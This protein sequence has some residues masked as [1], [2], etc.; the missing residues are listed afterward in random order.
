MKTVVVTGASRGFGRA[1]AVE[2]SA[3]AKVFAIGR[4]AAAL[5][6]TVALA[7]ADRVQPVVLDL[8][9]ENAVTDFFASL[10]S[11]DILINNAGIAQVKPLLD[12]STD[13]LRDVLE[14]NLVAAFVVMREGA[15]KMAARGGGHIINIA[16]D[17]AMRG[18]QN[19]TAYCASKHALLGMSRTAQL[20]LH[21]Q[22]VRVTSFNPG[23][24]K[25]EILGELSNQDSAMPTQE[26]ARL[27]VHLS[28]IPPQIAVHEI[29]VQPSSL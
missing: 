27:V 9:D 17:A 28:Q 3:S 2:F 21:A 29:L 16:S 26:L 19:M 20:E 1:L 24:I 23:P 15:R 10:D 22:N 14:T 13:D 6:E 8:R 4:D 5:A 7:Q 25:T 12:S 18:I 11:L